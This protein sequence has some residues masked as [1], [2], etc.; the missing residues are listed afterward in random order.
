MSMPKTTRRPITIDLTFIGSGRVVERPAGVFR[1]GVPEPALGSAFRFNVLPE[2]EYEDGSIGPTPDAVGHQGS[3]QINLAGTASDYRELGRH[4][5]AIAELDSSADPGFHQH[6]DGL[7]STDGRTQ[8]N[9]ILRK[10]PG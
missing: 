1:G 8:I 2:I 7:R 10:E 6:Y 4:L 9:L 5:L 3:L